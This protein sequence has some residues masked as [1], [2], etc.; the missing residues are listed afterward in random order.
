MKNFLKEKLGSGDTVV[1]TWCTLPSPAVTNVLA[2]GGMDYVILDMEHGPITFET[3]EEMVRAAE[4]AGCSPIIRP[5][6]AAGSEILRALETGAHG[7]IVPQ[8][9]SADDVRSI[10][11]A[12]KYAP[13]GARGHSPFTR[14]GGYS[15][16]DVQERLRAANRET[17]V[18]LIVE[19]VDGLNNLSSILDVSAENIDLVYFG[20]YDL[21]QSLGHPG[22]VRHPEVIEAIGECVKEASRFGIALGSLAN[23]FDDVALLR[24]AGLRFIAFQG[25]CSILLERVAEI[26]NISKEDRNASI[27]NEP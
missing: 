17:M 20:P 2:L 23:D 16:H 12:A 21:S 1:G 6:S 22:N 11:S 26:V 19:G 4:V 14:A 15:R 25:E 5:S 3:A 18:A 27:I 10:I 9:Q 8:V 7:I 24:S 13:I